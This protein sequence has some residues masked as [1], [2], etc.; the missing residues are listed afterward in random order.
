M[1]RAEP[2]PSHPGLV[3]ARLEQRPSVRRA[4]ARA[5]GRDLWR[6]ENNVIAQAFAVS[7]CLAVIIAIAVQGCA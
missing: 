7:F 6:E 1:R 3:P 2:D 4:L 5:N